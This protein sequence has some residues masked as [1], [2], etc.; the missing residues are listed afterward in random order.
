M[1][2]YDQNATASAT[3]PSAV[4]SRRVGRRALSRSALRRSHAGMTTIV[5]GLPRSKPQASSEEPRNPS[6]SSPTRPTA[7]HLGEHRS[8]RTLT[9]S[10]A[11]QRMSG[12]GTGQLDSTTPARSTGQHRRA[13]HPTRISLSNSEQQPLPPTDALRKIGPQRHT[14]QQTE[15]LHG[16]T[17]VHRRG[18]RNTQHWLTHGVGG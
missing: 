8:G 17:A 10:T 18:P 4:L 6:S 9:P 16:S 12:T 7:C 2:W 13:T 11:H 15:G 14:E 5:A 1:T 3:A